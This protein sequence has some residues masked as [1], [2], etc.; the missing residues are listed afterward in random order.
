[1]SCDIYVSEG[2]RTRVVAN[3][4]D[5]TVSFKADGYYWF[6]YRYFAGANLDR[7]TELIDLYGDA[8]I[9]GYQLHRLRVELESAL[10]DVAQKQ[11]RWLVL[12]GWNERP[13]IENEIWREV[14]RGEMVDLIQRL[15]WLI[16][17]AR[18]QK[19]NLICFGD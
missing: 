13:A 8:E 7:R 3:P 9:N 11:D 10:T 4:E 19:L 14:D 16:N 1:M 2:G 18:E 12:T 15:L 17:F 6:L 5:R